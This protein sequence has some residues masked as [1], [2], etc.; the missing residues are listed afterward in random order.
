MIQLFSGLPKLAGF[1]HFSKIDVLKIGFLTAKKSIPM[2][3]SQQITLSRLKFC[4]E[5][6]K[7]EIFHDW[8]Q[9]LAK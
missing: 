3:W 6:D 7:E 9:I 4:A 8:N 5:F 1:E 2:S